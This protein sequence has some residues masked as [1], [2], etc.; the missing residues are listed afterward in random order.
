MGAEGHCR[1]WPNLP[2]LM[3]HMALPQPTAPPFCLL[4][5]PSL[6]RGMVAPC[7]LTPAQLQC[8]VLEEARRR[9][10]PTVFP[11]P[12]GEIPTVFD[13]WFHGHLPLHGKHMAVLQDL[14]CNPVHS[15]LMRPQPLGPSELCK[16]D[17]YSRRGLWTCVPVPK[18]CQAGG[19]QERP[20]PS[21]CSPRKPAPRAPEPAGNS[22][23]SLSGRIFLPFWKRKAA[24]REICFLPSCF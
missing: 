17:V 7:S 3:L 12:L 9:P 15:C 21:S 11:G 8:R 10:V 6:K 14:V 20:A 2:T 19:N 23:S 5:L 4:S 1:G 18:S 16:E 22:S 24:S 13:L